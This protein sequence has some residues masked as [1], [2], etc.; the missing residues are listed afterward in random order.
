MTVERN[1]LAAILRTD[2]PAFVERAF[3]EVEPHTNL[4][5]EDYILYVAEKLTA[6]ADGSIK[7]L[8]INEPPRHQ[9]RY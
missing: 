6:V 9:S 8:I 3:A 1:L 7:H 5:A 4:V 2:L